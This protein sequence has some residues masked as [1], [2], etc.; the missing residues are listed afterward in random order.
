MA[1]WLQASLTAVLIT[2]LCLAIGRT[3]SEGWLTAWFLLLF[4]GGVPLALLSLRDL[5]ARWKPRRV[6]RS[7]L[8]LHICALFGAVIGYVVGALAVAS[9][10]P[11]AHLHQLMVLVFSSPC[12]LGTTPNDGKRHPVGGNQAL[13]FQ[14]R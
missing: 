8:L 3:E 9:E 14:I 1:P 2:G 7:Q 4:F 6:G 12:V 11:K 13:L 5:I 10:H